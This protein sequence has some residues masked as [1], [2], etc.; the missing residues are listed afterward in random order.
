LAAEEGK[1]VAHSGIL[2]MEKGTEASVGSD[3]PSRFSA[4]SFR[5]LRFALTSY[6]CFFLNE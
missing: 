5:R 4:P 1:T 6:S 2:V 3:F